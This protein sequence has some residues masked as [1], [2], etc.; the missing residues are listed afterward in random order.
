MQLTGHSQFCDDVFISDSASQPP[1]IQ[2]A[3]TEEP[4]GRNTATVPVKEAEVGLRCLLESNYLD[5]TQTTCGTDTR[6]SDP[7][8]ERLQRKFLPTPLCSLASF[9]VARSLLRV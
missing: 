7:L 6:V 3:L 4:Q 9:H 2:I 5:P 8:R 1:P